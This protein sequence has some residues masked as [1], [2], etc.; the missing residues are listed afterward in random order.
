MPRLSSL[1]SYEKDTA[2]KRPIN[3][4]LLL[5]TRL[6][7]LPELMRTLSTRDNTLKGGARYGW[8]KIIGDD[9][10]A[11]HGGPR[12]LQRLGLGLRFGLRQRLGFRFG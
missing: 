9:A 3:P 8:K 11:S 2:A 6:K 12:G 4:M 1:R 10:G 5:L 7:C